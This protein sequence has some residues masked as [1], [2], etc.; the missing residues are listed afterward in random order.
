MVVVLICGHV[1]KINITSD[2]PGMLMF[3]ELDHP[4]QCRQDEHRIHNFFRFCGCWLRVSD[5][6]LIIQPR[7]LQ[8]QARVNQLRMMIH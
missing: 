7:T 4:A 8:V 6:L 5:L 3:F 2:L 1:H